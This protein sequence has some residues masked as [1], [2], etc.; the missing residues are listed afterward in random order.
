[1]AQLPEATGD[2]GEPRFRDAP[3][4]V[5]ARAI[6][7]AEHL[8][9]FAQTEAPRLGRLDEPDAVNGVD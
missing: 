3:G 6:F 8:C 1:V 7:K 9:H 5:T 4:L 2:Y